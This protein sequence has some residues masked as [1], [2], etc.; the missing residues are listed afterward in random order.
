LRALQTEIQRV[1]G[2]DVG[3]G[4]RAGSPG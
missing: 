4:G 1:M 2:V 3:T